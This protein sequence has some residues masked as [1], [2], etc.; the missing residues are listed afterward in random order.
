MGQL[1]DDLL[2][3]S[4][5]NRQPLHPRPVALNA[6]VDRVLREL[7]SEIGQRPI[8]WKIS[9]LPQAVGDPVLL[10]QVFANLLAN[11]V[12]FTRPRNPAVIE[13]GGEVVGGEAI[14]FVRD[15][16]VGFDMRY[17]DKLFGI[18][19]RLHRAEEFEGTGVGLAVVQ[20]IV[21]RHGGRVWA[22]AQQNR[23]ACF[24][25]TLG[26]YAS[27]ASSEVQDDVAVGN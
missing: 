11:A 12:K 20:R 16:G 23:G 19:Q 18:F 13:V 25:F 3:L 9:A 2:E 17:A 24:Y 27:R 5:M 6:I 4:R 10:Q 26:C 8:E 15:N 1:V 21:R 7:A 14:F 22:E